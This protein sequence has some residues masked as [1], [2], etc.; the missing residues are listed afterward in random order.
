MFPYA[1]QL[2]F[3]TKTICKNVIKLFEYNITHKR[4]NDIIKRKQNV[5]LQNKIAKIS[6]D[7]Y[8]NIKNNNNFGRAIAP[9]SPRVVLDKVFLLWKN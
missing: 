3:A 6:I 4:I 7:I 1:N 8:N 5:I 2:E 9:P